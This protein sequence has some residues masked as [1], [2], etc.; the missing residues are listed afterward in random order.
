MRIRRKCVILQAE[1]TKHKVMTTIQLRA[2]LF[3]EMSPLLDNETAMTRLLA[4]MRE[5][6]KNSAKSEQMATKK[7]LRE[8]WAAAA[9]KAHD[10]G[11]D[12]LIMDDVFADEAM[13]GWKW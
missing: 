3:Q 9:Q 11:Q 13:E 1:T 5:L 2:E 7:S 4:F 12:K 6:Q 8:G 10:E